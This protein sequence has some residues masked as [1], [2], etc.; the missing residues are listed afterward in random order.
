MSSCLEYVASEQVGQKTELHFAC[1]RGDPKLIIEAVKKVS[2]VACVPL[3]ARLRHACRNFAA[4]TRARAKCCRLTPFPL[5]QGISINAP[6][7]VRI[8]MLEILFDIWN[9]Q[10]LFP[11]CP[12]PPCL[13][14]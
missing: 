4:A 14:H 11:V 6:D 12:L 13:L 3:H 7:D 10:Q 9:F 2:L 8:Y 5:E 1:C